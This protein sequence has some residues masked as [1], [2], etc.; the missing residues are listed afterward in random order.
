MT[1]SEAN[2]T[3]SPSGYQSSVVRTPTGEAGSSAL[4]AWRI[5]F[6]SS[7]LFR[8]GDTGTLS[9]MSGVIPVC[10]SLSLSAAQPRSTSQ[11]RESVR[12]AGTFLPAPQP[13]SAASASAE[14]C[15]LPLAA[16]PSAA[17]VCERRFAATRQRCRKSERTPNHALQR[18]LGLSRG[19]LK[20]PAGFLLKLGE[21]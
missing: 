18:L 19:S 10:A 12:L 7:A 1:N 17:V 6:E 4:A 21:P 5:G 11:A 8:F 3:S 13:H 14:Q 16:E 20:C 2:V 9:A 15:S